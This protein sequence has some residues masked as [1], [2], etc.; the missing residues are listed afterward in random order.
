MVR[1]LPGLLELVNYKN[2]TPLR[3]FLS[4]PK[5]SKQNLN[6]FLSR[7]AR[8]YEGQILILT[9]EIPVLP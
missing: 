6:S 3:P 8:G 9:Q 1:N 2:S 7:F 4:I 5:G